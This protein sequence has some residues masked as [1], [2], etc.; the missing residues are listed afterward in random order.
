MF[1]VIYQFRLK[2]HQETTYKE[3]W[4]KIVNYFLEKRGAIGSCLHKGKDGLWV[5]R[6]DEYPSIIQSWWIKYRT[7]ISS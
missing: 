1:T 5:A 3:C 2:S 6:S 4:N 7:Q